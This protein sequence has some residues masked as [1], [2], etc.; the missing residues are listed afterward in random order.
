[1]ATN[2]VLGVRVMLSALLLTVAGCAA[3]PA[4]PG[5]SPV[6]NGMP[7]ASK[8]SV[9]PAAVGADELGDVPILMYHQ[10]SADPLGEYDQTP[11][12]FRA[13]LERLYRED[14]RPVT[15]AD[16]VAGAINIP[17]GTHPVVLTFDDSTVSQLAFTPDGALVPDTAVA[18]LEDFAARH[19]DFPARATFYVN[20]EAFGNAP[21]ALK[22]LVAH[23]YE[24]G[25]HTATHANL[26]QLDSAGVQREFGENVRE[27]QTATASKVHTMALPLG[28][29]PADRALASQGVWAGVPYKFDAVMLVGAEPAPS[30]Y[31]EIDRGGI[32]RIRSGK[33]EVAFDSAYWLDRLA[34][35]R[36]TSDGDPNKISFP[37]QRGTELAASWRDRAN[38][39]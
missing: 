5:P 39:Y 8:A 23:G 16:Y 19:P 11:A 32:P 12:E 35:S 14:Y 28:I 2:Q 34:A 27:I 25:S 10:L 36:Y 21:G 13:E 9:A 1:M 37:A 3:D 15:V 30:P 7:A 26:G 24:V 4:A 6:A 20:N 29:F 31:G 22:W 18:I 17:A 33:G 38:P